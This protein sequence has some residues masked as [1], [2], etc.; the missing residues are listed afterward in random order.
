[1]TGGGWLDVF[2]LIDGFGWHEAQ[3]LDLLGDLLPHRRPL[4]TVLGYSSG[5]IPTLLTGKPPAEHGH[6]NLFYYDPAGSPFRWLRPF[7]VLPAAILD[8]R[9]SRKVLK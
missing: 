1:M 3:E 2:V 5:A 8:N 7:G 9:L 6:W 4:R